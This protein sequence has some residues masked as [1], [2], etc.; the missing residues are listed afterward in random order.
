MQPRVSILLPAYDAESTLPAC[1]RSIE[2]QREGRFEC[3]VVDDGSRDATRDVVREFSSRDARFVLVKAPHRGLVETLNAGLAHCRAPVV[4]RMDA[5]DWMHRDRLAAQLEKL[6]SHPE[7]SA[8]GSHVR[9]FPR[10]REPGGRR[11]YEAW[12]GGIESAEQVRAD[13]FVECSIAHPTLMI[14]RELLVRFRYRECGWPEDYDLLLRLLTSGHEVGV[15]PRRLLGWREHAGRLSRT[16]PAYGL[17]RFTAC[18]AAHLAS[19]LLADSDRYI[20]WGYGD[21]GRELCRALRVHEKKPALIV[22]R[23][24][25]RIGQRIQGAPVISPE[26]LADAP[27]LPIVASVAGRDAR[28]QIRAFLR[29][30]GRREGQDFVC[31][32]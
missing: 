5:D 2:R 4:A 24:P 28:E 30:I 3:I 23:H 6:D 27:Q 1:L 20:L 15:V 31:A 7:L 8:V 9:I 25:G 14:R 13:A 29:Q 17:E 21:T 26:Q 19:S 12:L 16:H 32:A 22:E 10:T 11:S 18:K